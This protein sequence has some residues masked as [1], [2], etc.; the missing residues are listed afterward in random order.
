[1]SDFEITD[2]LIIGLGIAGGVCA[3]ELAKKGIRVTVLL[4]ETLEEDGNTHYAQGGIVYIGENDSPEK[5]YS[6]IF[7]AGVGVNNPEAVKVVAYDGHLIVKK[8]LIDEIGVEFVRDQNGLLEFTEEGAHSVK[9]IIYSGD[10]TGKAIISKLVSKL[11]TFENVTILEKHIAIDLITWQFHSRDKF[12]MYKDKTCLGAYVFDEVNN[13]VKNILAKAT[14]LAT[15]GMGR[16]YLHNTNPDIA[17]GDGYAMAYRIG[18]EIINMEYTQFHPTTLF[19]PLKK[20]FLISESVR[21]EGG[22][23]VNSK[24]E[25][26]LFKYDSRGELAPRDIVTRGIISEI[27]ETKDDC[28][29]LDASRIGLKDKLRSRFPVIFSTLESIGIDMSKDLIPVVPA[30]H[31]QCGG[32]KTDTFG[33]TNIKRLFAVGEVACT[34]LHGANRLASTSLLEGVV[35]GYRCASFISESITKPTF[36]EFPDVIEW[37]DTGK[38][39]PDPVLIKQDWDY[40][41]NIMWNYVGPIRTRRRLKRALSDIKNLLNDIEDFYR[42]VKVNRDIIELRNGVQTGFLVALSAWSNRESIGS[43]YRID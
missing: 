25:R 19:H 39:Y 33:K 15:G 5:I 9:R 36:N 7:L 34:G 4:K 42:D 28:V 23:I 8:L 17:T 37:I 18:A 30:F 31:F 41:R 2:V 43:H 6:D 32:V 10:K 26:F 12:R 29:F 20:N 11:K 40:I 16:V 3:Y 13:K 38:E 27:T 24:G 22:I 35:F 14:V 1:M 21:G